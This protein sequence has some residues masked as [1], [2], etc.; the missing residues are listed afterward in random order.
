[1]VLTHHLQLQYDRWMSAQTHGTLYVAASPFQRLWHQKQAR[2]CCPCAQYED[3]QSPIQPANFEQFQR[4]SRRGQILHVLALRSNAFHSLES[5]DGSWILFSNVHMLGYPEAF[6]CY[7]L[8]HPSESHSPSP[9]S[10]AWGQFAPARSPSKRPDH[11]W[12]IGMEEQNVF[13]EPRDSIPDLEERHFALR[14][15]KS[16]LQRS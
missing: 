6:Y 12:S 3:V 14:V 7:V 13:R 16:Q 4:M 8:T 5:Q 1:M 15:A 2:P 10:S 9:S 11:V